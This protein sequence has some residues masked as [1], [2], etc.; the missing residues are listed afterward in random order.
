MQ[1]GT[2]AEMMPRQKLGTSAHAMTV[3]N[4]GITADKVASGW[5]MVPAGFIGMWP[6][7]TAHGSPESV[8]LDSIYEP[9]YDDLQRIPFADMLKLEAF[10]YIY[11][12]SGRYYESSFGFSDY[13]EL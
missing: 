8:I 3:A 10:V 2:N 13:S 4:G 1:V 11:Q 6:M 5:G 7:D 9:F 12:T